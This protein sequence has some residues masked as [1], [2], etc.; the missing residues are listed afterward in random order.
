MMKKVFVE[1]P[2]GMEAKWVNGVLTLVNSDE[3]EDKR[4]IIERIK[5]FED[6]CN[7][8]GIEAD[9]WIKDKEELGFEGDVIAYMKL[10]IIC[11]ALNEGWRPNL[12]EDEYRYYPWYY[13]YTQEELDNMSNSERKN[14]R[15][16][17]FGGDADGGTIAGFGFAGTYDAPSSAD[18][19][20]GSRL[21]L[22]SDE[23]A[24]Y[25]GKQF[26]EIWFNYLFPDFTIT[27]NNWEDQ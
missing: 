3:V 15:G 22:K 20:F 6:A 18:A 10:R 8:I 2:E 23:L 19:I 26:I 21:C 14:R 13:L 27:N 12:K 17:L 7:E 1:I 25:C 11:N 5:T 9:K 24:T 4:S 16:L